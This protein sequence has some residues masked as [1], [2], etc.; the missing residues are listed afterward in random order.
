[1]DRKCFFLLIH[2]KLIQHFSLYFMFLF[3]FHQI[4][5]M[6]ASLVSASE[7]IAKFS[8]KGMSGR[9][10]FTEDP[11][12]MGVHIQVDPLIGLEDGQDYE[13]SIRTLPMLYD[14]EDR[15]AEEYIGPRVQEPHRCHRAPYQRHHRVHVCRFNAD[16][17]WKW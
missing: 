9:V 11:S 6:L 14:R 10:I 7:H 12:T 13:W 2:I 15:C 4:G 3:F 1:M 16:V 5:L 8:M 17:R